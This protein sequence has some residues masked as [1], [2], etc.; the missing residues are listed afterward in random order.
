[1]LDQSFSAHNFETIYS[2]E[3]RKGN[4]DVNTM[5]E[6]YRMVIARAEDIKKEIESTQEEINKLNNINTRVAQK[7]VSELNERLEELN[8]QLDKAQETVD[9][10]NAISADDLLN[11]VKSNEQ[12]LIDYLSNRKMLDNSGLST[13]LIRYIKDMGIEGNNMMVA[14]L[15][16]SNEQIKEINESYM[17]WKHQEGLM[18]MED[19]KDRLKKVNSFSSVLG[20]LADKLPQKFLMEAA[21]MGLDASDLLESLREFSSSELK[22]LNTLYSD[23]LSIDTKA[24]KDIVASFAK[25]GMDSAKGFGEGLAK[26]TSSAVKS[27]NKFA[28][29][30]QN[31]VEKALGLGKKKKKKKAST[32]KKA[33]VT[34]G[35]YAVDVVNGFEEEVN[36]LVTGDNGYSP[37]DALSN[38]LNDL[39]NPENA[40]IITPVLDLTN[41][42]NGALT[43][44]D[45]LNNGYTLAGSSNFAM[46]MNSEATNARL[47]AVYSTPIE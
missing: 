20:D 42:S 6:E 30:I 11:N 13:S 19:F 8:E 31:E 7:Q 43:I 18:W 45:L 37:L 41:V 39:S 2:L 9:K 26:G 15:S 46:N 14:A 22:D 17:N 24:A 1:M 34:G 16:L 35:S 44:Q 32:K 3:S 5:P 21:N 28:K 40:P 12:G 29:K 27:A 36:E 10:A 33:K 38:A 23:S 25:A 4:I 47:A